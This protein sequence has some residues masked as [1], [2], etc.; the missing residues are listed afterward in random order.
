M[1]SSGHSLIALGGPAG[2]QGVFQKGTALPFHPCV[3]S[4]S[5]ST[6]AMEMLLEGCVQAAVMRPLCPWLAGQ[7]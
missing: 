4:Q 3:T 7:G 5:L 6:E 1:G 2:L